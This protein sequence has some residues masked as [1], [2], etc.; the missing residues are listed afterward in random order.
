M[1]ETAKIRMSPSR[2]SWRLLP[3]VGGGFAILLNVST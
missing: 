1:T 2:L 3:H